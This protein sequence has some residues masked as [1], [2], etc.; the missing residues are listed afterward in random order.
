G[1]F[2]HGNTRLEMIWTLIPAVIL[3][4]L[5]LAS[6][7]VWDRYRYGEEYLAGEP[8]AELMVIGEQF[9]WNFVYPGKDGKLGQYMAFPQPSDPEFADVK[10]DK[11]VA[12][13]NESITSNPLGQN[14]NWSNE[15]AKFGQDD[16]YDPNPGR[17]LVLPVER[18]IAI[19]L[20]SKD[21]IHD[22]F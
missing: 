20:S 10:G 9:K 18:P 17:P 8:P 22:F 5:A 11:L 4:V 14:K 15:E 3:A 21:V 2:I 6:K 16:D 13:V 7:G 12:A 1:K 19:K